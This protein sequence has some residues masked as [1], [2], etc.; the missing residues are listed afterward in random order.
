MFRETFTCPINDRFM[1]RLDLHPKLEVLRLTGF[2]PGPP[3]W[4]ASSH[5]NS[6]LIIIRNIDIWVRDMALPQ[7][8]CY[9]NINEHT[10]T[11]L[12]CRSN[13]ICKADGL[14]PAVASHLFPKL[15]V[16]KLTSPGRESNPGLRRWEQLVNSYSE[17]LHMRRWQILFFVKKTYFK[18]CVGEP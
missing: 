11:A 5:S 4:E 18:N 8:M 14:M 17:H 12:G 10:W 6:L 15:E 1:K 2:E 16:P 7:C 13:S 3:R 9:M